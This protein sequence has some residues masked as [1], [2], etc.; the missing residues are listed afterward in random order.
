MARKI[1]QSVD[2]HLK[3]VLYYLDPGIVQTVNPLCYWVFYAD[4]SPFKGGHHMTAYVMRRIIIGVIVLL[5]VTMMVFLVVRLLPGDP[6]VIF[7]GQSFTQQQQRIGPE[8]YEAL[9]HQWGLDK[10]MPVQYWDWLTDVLRGDL[11]KSIKVNV[12]ISTLIA[13]RMP[14]T[15]YI[16]IITLVFSSV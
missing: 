14:R 10:P 1:S 6:L 9:R 11:G 8:E 16:G 4:S 5:I 12:P 7:L 15:I 2:R 3:A 13:E